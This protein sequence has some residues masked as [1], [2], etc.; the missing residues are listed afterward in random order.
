MM[1]I[2][3]DECVSKLMDQSAGDKCVYRK[4]GTM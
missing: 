2:L 3:S 4:N 1:N